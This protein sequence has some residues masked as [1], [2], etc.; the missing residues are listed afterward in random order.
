[1]PLFVCIGAAI[2][3]GGALGLSTA[4]CGNTYWLKSSLSSAQP[5]AIEAHPDSWPALDTLRNN[6]RLNPADIENWIQLGQSCLEI[7]MREGDSK[8]IIEGLEAFQRALALD[9]KRPEAL[10]NIAAISL[11]MGVYDKALE[12]YTRYLADHPQDQRIAKMAE[13]A[14][15]HG[16][17][18]K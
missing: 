10:L 13:L 6:A 11:E 18:P 17:T 3:W 12:Y 16:M 2:L 8:T 4:L 14:R 9:P 15:S 1:M 5:T 7:G